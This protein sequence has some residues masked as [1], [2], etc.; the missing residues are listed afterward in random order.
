MAEHKEKTEKR[1][2]TCI[3]CPL[4]CALTAIRE[5][6]GE[7]TVTGNACPRGA[8]YAKNEWT[9]PRR[10]VTTTVRVRRDG[11]AT[12]AVGMVSVKTADA[13]PKDKIMDCIKALAE[14]ELKAPVQIGDVVLTNVS[15]TGIDVVATKNYL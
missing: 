8:A 5:E 2:M 10:T 11:E 3:C 14:V 12:E 13:I 9:D 15:E 4:G 7:I 6:N 1:E